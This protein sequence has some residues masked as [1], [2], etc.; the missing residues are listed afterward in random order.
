MAP[1]RAALQAGFGGAVSLEWER[2]WHPQLAPL[3]EALASATRLG[4]W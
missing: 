1:L 4:W 2:L 3:D